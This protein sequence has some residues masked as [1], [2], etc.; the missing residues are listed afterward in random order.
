MQDQAGN[1]LFKVDN[2][3]YR[4]M[5][6][7]YFEQCR[8]A[9]FIESL[10]NPLSTA[11]IAAQRE[12]FGVIQWEI[13][14]GKFVFLDDFNLKK[15]LSGLDGGNLHKGM[16]I[17][18]QITSELMANFTNTGADNQSQTSSQQPVNE[19]RAEDTE[20]KTPLTQIWDKSR[21]T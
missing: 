5:K 21:Q 1:Y 20:T 10:I 3:N 11:G 12:L 16:Q 2:V 6:M 9:G 19:S 18:L 7:D 15:L 8:I 17:L 13:E 14:P 4:V